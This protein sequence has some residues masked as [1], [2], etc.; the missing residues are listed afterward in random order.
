MHASLDTQSSP[1]SLWKAAESTA[2]AGAIIYGVG[3]FFLAVFLAGLDATPEEAGFSFSFI[4]VRVSMILV[5]A[6]LIIVASIRFAPQPIRAPRKEEGGVRLNSRLAAVGS[7]V[8]AG[9]VVTFVFGVAYSAKPWNLV[10]PPLARMAIILL[11]VVI[12]TILAVAAMASILR[13]VDF[14]HGEPYVI[15]FPRDPG[16]RSPRGR[17]HRLR[18]TPAEDLLAILS[19]FI[20]IGIG[21]GLLAGGNYLSSRVQSGQEFSFMGFRVD[22][23]VVEYAPVP[24]SFSTEVIQP[25]TDQEHLES[26]LPASGSCLLLLGQ[27]SANYLLYDPDDRRTLRA[28]STQI[29]LSRNI[30]RNDCD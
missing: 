22:A 26:L 1:L 19:T 13:R 21:G 24:A 14:R 28:P 15:L 6:V 12:A 17:I 18:E 23:V 4:V 29:F 10:Q 5:L 11:T 20:V 2:L 16:K 9:L 30:D 3:W 27:S 7:I 25:D 8:A